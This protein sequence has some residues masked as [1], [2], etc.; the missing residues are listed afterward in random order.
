MLTSA[1]SLR[2][3]EPIVELVLQFNH[4]L[5]NQ[6]L[7][8]VAAHLIAAQLEASLSVGGELHRLMERYYIVKGVKQNH[9]IVA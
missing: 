7:V 6:R 1:C 4:K 9:E 3:V 5:G 8:G 2:V